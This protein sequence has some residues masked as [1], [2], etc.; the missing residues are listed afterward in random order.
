M[1]R[2]WNQNRNPPNKLLPSSQ[3]IRTQLQ[4]WLVRENLVQG[5]L[6]EPPPFTHCLYTDVS[7]K[8]W[9]AHLDNTTCQGV[10]DKTEAQFCI[11]IPPLSCPCGPRQH[12]CC[13]LYQ[14]S[15]GGGDKVLV[16]MERDRVAILCG[17]HPQHLHPCQIYPRQ[18][19]CYSF[20]QWGYPNLN[21]FATRFHTKCPTFVS[22]APDNRSLDTDALA[23]SWEGIFAYALPP[24]Q[25][26]TQSLLKFRQVMCHLTSPIVPKQ[27]WF[28]D[29]LNS[30]VNHPILL[31]S[32]E[33]RL[34]QPQSNIYHLN[35]HMLNLH[36][37]KLC[38]LA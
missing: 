15:G 28:P 21:L 38:S 34:K 11:N 18:D 35:P 6:L 7:G 10:W 17:S 26:L 5:I 29:L 8:G 25:F 33:K 20:D 19:E 32:W 30:S 14:Q 31:P 12:Y 24:Q 16:P 22:P 13:C 4:W 9:G 23:M 36:S 37:W 27:S 1:H 3:T 2:F